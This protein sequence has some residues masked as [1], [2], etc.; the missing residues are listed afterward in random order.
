MDAM[1]ENGTDK[2]AG[3]DVIVVMTNLPDAQSAASLSRSVLQARLA[4]CVN[5]LGPC[6]SEYWWQG[7]LEQAEEWPVLIKTTRARYAELEALIL[8]AHPYDVPEI[9]AMPLVA[10]FAPY[11]A[12][13]AG[14]TGAGANME[15]DNG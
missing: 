2:Q 5:R 4:A 9:V 6:Q 8:A 15:E 1:S 10:G 7:G 13:A 12:W 11:L 3:S 14:E